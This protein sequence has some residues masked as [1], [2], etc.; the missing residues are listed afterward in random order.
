MPENKYQLIREFPANPDFVLSM[1][2]FRTYQRNIGISPSDIGRFALEVVLEEGDEARFAT[3]KTA[4]DKMYWAN[5][6]DGVATVGESLMLFE[7]AGEAISSARG[8]KFI[9]AKVYQLRL[10]EKAKNICLDVA[11]VCPFDHKSMKTYSKIT[12]ADGALVVCQEK[13][14]ADMTKG[15]EGFT[16][17]EIQM[18]EAEFEALPEFN[19]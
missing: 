4:D 6:L 3:P 5:G 8:V 15:Q 19:D 9:S 2:H 13:E 14:V 16:V 7:T 1:P 18:T 11:W 17:E 10:D 12:F